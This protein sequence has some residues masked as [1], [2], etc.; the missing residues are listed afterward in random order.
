MGGGLLDYSDCGKIFSFAQLRVGYVAD[1]KPLAICAGTASVAARA[2]AVHIEDLGDARALFADLFSVGSNSYATES[3]G[4]ECCG[5]VFNSNHVSSSVGP[6]VPWRRPRIIAGLELNIVNYRIQY[7]CRPSDCCDVARV[8]LYCHKIP[9][10]CDPMIYTCNASSSATTRRE[11][12]AGVEYMVVPVVMIVDGVL[13]GALVTH[14]EYGPADVWNGRPVMI[15]H[16]QVNGEY[17]GASAPDIIERLCVGQIFNASISGGTLSAE[18]WINVPQCEKLGHSAVL[19]AL[20]A[21]EILEVS[22]GYFSKREKRAGEFSGVEYAYAD[23]NIRPDHLALLLDEEGACSVK[24]G[25]GT[26]PTVFQRLAQA[27]GLRAHRHQGERTMCTKKDM[28]DNLVGNAKLSAEQIEL[29]MGLD[30]EQLAMMQAIASGMAA[31]AVE[32]EVEAK[33]EAKE[34]DE[35][36]D[37]AAVVNSV[38]DELR[39]DAVIERIVANSSNALDDATLRAMSL[40]QLGKYEQAIRPTDYSGMGG[41]HVVAHSA[42]AVTPINSGG[43]VARIKGVK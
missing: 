27:F 25:C 11:T 31:T 10:T 24:D 21:G 41:T 4:G 34:E 14:E 5:V 8:A 20:E 33:E 19:T 39:K 13:N 40:D 18:C 1:V 37:M 32:P 30:P 35:E 15:G 3:G 22:T 7:N 6:V 2:M 28:V 29:L 36:V 12:L 42:E 9:H 17:V 38:R 23:V 26:R 43:L 16:P